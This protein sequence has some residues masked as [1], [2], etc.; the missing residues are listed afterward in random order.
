MKRFVLTVFF[1]TAAASASGG[2]DLA[3]KYSCL[4]CHQVRGRKSAPAFRGIANRNLRFNGDSAQNGIIAS[5]K[6]GSEGKY[7]NFAGAKMPPY[8]TIPQKDLEILADWILSL[9]ADRGYG[10]GRRAR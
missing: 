2:M 8:P 5:I 9:A 6:N 7:P 1:L 10:A 4:A 3:E